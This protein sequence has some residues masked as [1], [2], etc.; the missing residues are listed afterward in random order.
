[1]KRSRLALFQS[2]VALLLCCSMLIGTT[3]A[4]FTD[5]VTSG[6]NT[7]AAGTLDIELEYRD[8]DGNWN[9]VN[10]RTE[11]LDKE[12]LWEPGYTE[13]AYLKVTNAGNLALK[14]AL[15]VGVL[16]ELGSINAAGQPFYLSDYIRF[17]VIESE[18]E[19]KYATREDALK[20]LTESQ[21]ISNGPVSSGNQLNENGEERYVTLVVYMPEDVGNAANYATGVTPPEIDLGLELVATQAE[22]EADSFGSSYDHGAGLKAFDFPATRIECS[23]S[24]GVESNKDNTSANGVT[25]TTKQASAEIPAG[26][27]LE[28]GANVLTLE[29]TTMDESDAN[30]TL[31]ANEAVRSLDVHVKGIAKDNTVPM[32]ITI[33]EAAPK[34]LNMGNYKFYHVENGQTVEMTYVESNADFTAHNQF[35]YDPAT[36]DIILYMATFSEVALVADTTGAWEGK[37]DYTWYDASKT[38]LTIANADQ[39][40]AFGAI[41]GGMAEGIEQDS[42]SG[43]TVKLISNINL[44][45]DEKNNKENLIFYPIGYN[46]SD[47]KYEKTGVAVTTGFYNFCGAFDGQGHTVAN[48]YQNTWEMKGDNEYY[49]ATLQYYRDGMG[50]FGKV[51]GGTIKN[52]TVDNFSSDGEYTT[53]GVIAAYADGA[54]F[55]NIAI[56][57][58]TPRVYNIGNGG[59]VGCVGWYAKEANLKTTFKNIT[60]DNSNK[61]S[62]LWGSYDV[63]CGGIVGQYYP[64]SGQSSANKPINGGISF[65]NCHIAAQMDVYNDVCGNYQYYAYRYAGMLIGSVRENVTIDG[66]VYPKMDGITAKDCTVH[67]GTWND[68]YYCEFEKN[69][70][71]SY[72]EDY[73]FSRVDKSEI[74]FDEKGN[75]IGCTHTHT[76]AEDKCAVYL[77]FN[78]LVTGYGWGVTTK[79]VGELDGVTILDR[80]VAESVEKFMGKV[81]E[82]ANNQEYK[83]GDIFSFIDNGVELVPDALT[84]TVTNLEENNPVSAEFKRDSENWENGTIIFSGTGKVQITIQ[85]YYYCSPTTIEVDIKERTEATK[86]E[87]KFTGD[88]LYRVGNAN[89][90]ALGSLFDIV[91]NEDDTPKYTIDSSKVDVAIEVQN[92]TGVSG[93]FTN[94]ASDWTKG[95]IKFEGTGVVK[96]TITDY[97]YCIPTELYL[98]VINAT[99]VPK[100][101]K[102]GNY[103]TTSVLLGNTTVSTLYLNG[104]ATLYGNGFTIDC[105]DSPVTGTGSVSE[106]YIIGLQNAHLDNVVVV[107]AVYTEYGATASSNNNRALVVSKGN[108]TITNCY[109]SNTAS[110]IRLVEGSLYVK[111]TTVK[112]GNFANIDVRNGHLTVEN[113]TTINEAKSNDKTENG[114][115]VIGLGIV[116]YYENV[117]TALTSVTIKGDLKQHNLISSNDKFSHEYATQLV[118]QMMSSSYKDFQYVIDGVTWVNPGYVAMTKVVPEDKREDKDKDGYIGK[119]VRFAAQDGYVYAVK[120]TTVNEDDNVG[121]GITTPGQGVIAPEYSFDYTTKNYIAKTDGSNDYCYYEDGKVL[122]AMDQGDTFEWDPFIL[123]VTKNGKTLDYT[124]TMNGNTYVSGKK[125]AFNT[126]GDYVVTYT[127]TDDNN[128][129]L[130]TVDT[131]E[132]TYVKTVNISV[133][134]I[135]PTTQHATFTFADTKTETE[136]IT[137]SDKTYISAK[138]VSATDKEWGYITVNGTKIFYPITEAQFKKAKLSSEYTV[139]YYVFNDTVTITDYKDGGTGGAQVYNAETTTMPSSLNVINGMEAKYTSIS[140]A[141]VDISKLTKDG[142]SG[143]VW[144]FSASTT[145]SGT[146]KYNEYLAHQSPSGL[147]I[148]SGTRDYDAITVAQF[149]YTDAA[150][151]T[152]YY[153]VGYF[154]P[155]QVSSSSSGGGGCVAPETLI[156]LA[157]GSLVRIDSLIGNEELLVWNHETGKYDVAPVAYIVNHDEAVEEHEITHL[158]FSDGSE[159]RV[160]NEHVF[161]DVTLNKYIALTGEN[162]EDYIGHKFAAVKDDNR[163]LKTVKLEKVEQYVE[164]TSVYEVVSYKHLTCFTNNILS[165]SAYLD[166]LLNVFDINPV[167]KAYSAKKVAKDIETYGLYTYDDFKDLISEEAFEMYNAAYLKV[168]V[169]KGYI[170]WDDILALID[171]YFNV[172][173]QPIQ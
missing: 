135:K 41:V 3:F 12:A 73:Q 152:Y 134:V 102:I 13:V 106:N 153:F 94:N 55:E 84:V 96:L 89:T 28:N 79:V 139:Y 165:T 82:L 148:K 67:F 18:D 83:L 155:N 128:Y 10:D 86:F 61:I 142:P 76:D 141:C 116:V 53:T 170:T 6:N 68:Y 133:S 5:G 127:Y 137:V 91:K 113:V 87:S 70:M 71:A 129:K 122:I 117:D 21:I 2:L 97:D 32:A 166:K 151:A 34:G 80:E 35:K 50:L 132:Q 156:T 163:K 64:T 101:G 108:S 26:V 52:L 118:D 37:F 143:E 46:S 130:R 95:T 104:G 114:A 150:G 14:Y 20:A 57:N 162:Y 92:G 120:P 11:V 158:Y 72:S 145:V 144:D 9:E 110:P 146:T 140:S 78:N 112:G 40:A 19:P 22:C 98:E 160:I 47:G 66:H 49:H 48:F 74:I 58:C 25:L 85:D 125:I 63:P 54:T 171:I 100:N 75:V 124:V 105:T 173:V 138:G 27:K 16:K 169:G 43:K 81:Y 29:V 164:E 172:D 88:F 161:Y 31:E 157:D 123:T 51:Y 115:T 8:A 167:T 15:G 107:G 121:D 111:G 154:M 45:D 99:N 39:L 65:E 77:P 59:I 23:T 60:V 126:A 93:S 4:W 136:K 30:I 17:G 131:Y 38:E 7:I 119:D 33:K 56:T 109:L 149:S 42:F 69:T 62:A 147:A 159:V 90:V 168:A 44:G 1:M 24:A 36:G 103:N